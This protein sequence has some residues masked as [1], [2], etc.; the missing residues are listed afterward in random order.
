LVFCLY[1]GFT[2]PARAEEPAFTITQIDGENYPT[3]HLT[4]ECS[5]WPAKINPPEFHILENRNTVAT[6]LQQIS[7]QQPTVIVFLL[8]IPVTEQ[9]RED[10][11]QQILQRVSDIVSKLNND[12]CI[13]ST[14]DTMMAVAPDENNQI[15]SE[16]PLVNFVSNPIT[17]TNSVLP[18]KPEAK[19]A[20]DPADLL[21]QVLDQLYVGNTH[22]HIVIFSDGSFPGDPVINERM[23][24]QK[25]RELQAQAG[26]RATIYG[27]F[28]AD[29]PRQVQNADNLRLLVGADNFCSSDDE[30]C[31]HAL[32]HRWTNPNQY[33]LTYT[34]TSKPP[35]EINAQA[36][37]SGTT[38]PMTATKLFWRDVQPLQ[39]QIITPTQNTVFEAIAAISTTNAV[40]LSQPING[41]IKISWPQAEHKRPIQ[42]IKYRLDNGTWQPILATLPI[43]LTGDTQTLPIDLG[44]LLIGSHRLQVQVRTDVQA[45]DA[46]A[47]TFFRVSGQML[48]IK[49]NTYTIQANNI[50]TLQTITNLDKRWLWLLIGTGLL[51]LAITFLAFFLWRKQ[52]S[53][54]QNLADLK[55]FAERLPRPAPGPIYVLD[56]LAKIKAGLFLLE[57]VG[58][59]SF[60]PIEQD[61]TTKLGSNFYQL[62]DDVLLDGDPRKDDPAYTDNG[63][64][65]YVVNNRY[66]DSPQ[67]TIIEKDEKITIYDGNGEGSSSKN[68]TYVNGIQ[69]SATKPGK[70]LNSGDE[71]RLGPMVRYSFR[72]KRSA[73][74]KE[75]QQVV[76][77]TGQIEEIG[78]E[79]RLPGENEPVRFV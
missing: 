38:L 56:E 75:I 17:L 37:I 35:F 34:T 77:H 55:V 46:E 8:D 50:T 66:I 30:S 15:N 12:P 47:E 20:T 57:G 58:L 62:P 70:E 52:N 65:Y 73:N 18:F 9:L 53:D 3:I 32:W 28:L 63:H 74:L 6:E 22:A 19:T 71:I 42:S 41:Q 39:L 31:L 78:A 29:A 27:V 21:S 25:A 13:W 23:R 43:S 2:Q 4:M 68:Y 61:K 49:R 44:R 45:F 33:E 59:L 36:V 40:T 76:E 5:D 24:A 69:I 72:R 16:K 7:K 64:A 10:D 48:E 54:E 67:C 60:I 79:L 14:F 51:A 11:A 26:D 1:F